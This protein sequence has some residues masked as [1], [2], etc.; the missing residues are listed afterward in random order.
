MLNLKGTI[1]CTGIRYQEHT[2][3]GVVPRMPGCDKY[4]TLNNPEEQEDKKEIHVISCMVLKHFFFCVP[5]PRYNLT[6]L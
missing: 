5:E 1:W 6:D 2:A 3:L 4:S